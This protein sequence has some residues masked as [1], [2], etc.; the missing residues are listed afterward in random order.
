MVK[1]A[2][3]SMTVGDDEPMSFLPPSSYDRAPSDRTII[4]MR[5]AFIA[6]K[7][8]LVNDVHRVKFSWFLPQALEDEF[9]LVIRDLD[10]GK[11]L[12]AG[13]VLA[14]TGVDP[15]FLSVFEWLT[16]SGEVN[17]IS[18]RVDLQDVAEESRK[19]PIKAVSLE[20]ATKSL[21]TPL[22]ALVTLEKSVEPLACLV[23][24]DPD[25][26][27]LRVTAAK[28]DTRQ[29]LFEGELKTA[30]AGARMLTSSTHAVCALL[31]H[32]DSILRDSFGCL[33]YVSL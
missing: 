2:L 28:D 6:L 25:A 32:H 33:Q 23:A 13:A 27:L 20:Q 16:M 30:I 3:H 24:F 5:D 17:G 11:N 4:A 1:L 12:S 26:Q 18:R 19:Q 14:D 15:M 21:T 8:Q 10:S 7:P 22:E 9:E 31:V 29:I